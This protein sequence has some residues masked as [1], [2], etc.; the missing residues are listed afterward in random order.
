MFKSNLVNSKVDMSDP[1][2][3]AGYGRI[4]NGSANWFGVTLTKG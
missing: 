2:I 4:W 1:N 3:A